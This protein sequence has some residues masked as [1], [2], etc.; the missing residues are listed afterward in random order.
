MRTFINTMF[1]I[2]FGV[3]LILTFGQFILMGYVA[4]KTMDIVNNDCKGSV[5]YCLG[6]AKK[7][8]EEGSK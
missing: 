8:Y 4:Y 3:A 7:Q 6:K 2:I 1:F 5:A